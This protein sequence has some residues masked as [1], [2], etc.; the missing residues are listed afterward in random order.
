MC[1]SYYI[2]RD[3]SGGKS[4]NA[5]NANMKLTSTVQSWSYEKLRFLCIGD[6]TRKEHEGFEIGSKFSPICLES[7]GVC[8]SC[9]SNITIKNYFCQHASSPTFSTCSVY[10]YCCFID[11]HYIVLMLEKGLKEMEG[12]NSGFW[13]KLR[14]FLPSTHW[15][16][17]HSSRLVNQGQ[18]EELQ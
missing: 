10:K 18:L 3:L 13:Q 17:H 8:Y 6:N 11:S 7:L 14:H 12:S 9:S 15:I 16:W 5:D 4:K 1:G 2:K